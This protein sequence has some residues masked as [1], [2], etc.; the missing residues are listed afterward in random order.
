MPLHQ[1][2]A[3]GNQTASHYSKATIADRFA[4]RGLRNRTVTKTAL[5]AMKFG[6]AR[7]MN[8]DDSATHTRESRSLMTN[9]LNQRSQVSETFGVSVVRSNIESAGGPTD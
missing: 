4:N 8:F 2:L 9:N 1:L 5:D 6:N 3:R 7:D